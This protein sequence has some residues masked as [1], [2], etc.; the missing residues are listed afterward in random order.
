MLYSLQIYLFCSPASSA[1]RLLPSCCNTRWGKDGGKGSQE[2]QD[3][4]FWRKVSHLNRIVGH[5]P[6]NLSFCDMLKLKYYKQNILKTDTKKKK[7]NLL[8]SQLQDY[9]HSAHWQLSSK[10][11][12]RCPQGI[13]KPFR[14]LSQVKMLWAPATNYASPFE[15]V[16]RLEAPMLTWH[17][18]KQKFWGKLKTRINNLLW[19]MSFSFF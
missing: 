9:T 15:G 4:S 18:Y 3:N 10:P 11:A 5:M 17:S 12:G 6:I 16:H 14:L 19:V 7:G 8:H 13:P 2:P 1:D